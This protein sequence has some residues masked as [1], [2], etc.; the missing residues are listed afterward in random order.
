MSEHASRTKPFKSGD[1]FIEMIKNE[2]FPTLFAYVSSGCRKRLQRNR[3]NNHPWVM[4]NNHVMI[5]NSPKL[6][7]VGRYV[8]ADT[9]QLS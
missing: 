8:K 1:H 3:D 5:E 6:S 9:E 4:A 7:R 2:K